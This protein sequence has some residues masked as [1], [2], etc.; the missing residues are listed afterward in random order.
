MLEEYR[1]RE[2]EYLER[3]KDLEEI[4]LQRDGVKREYD[5]LRKRRLDEFMAG[6][7]VISQKLKEMYQVRVFENQF[8][9]CRFFMDSLT[10]DRT[11]RLVD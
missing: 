2:E 11:G 1:R 3:A 8:T 6:F 4:T 7:N 10:P 9:F 5:D